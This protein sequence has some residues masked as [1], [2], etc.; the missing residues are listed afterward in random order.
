MLFQDANSLAA[1]YPRFDDFRAVRDRLDPERVFTND[2][3]R[4][5]LGS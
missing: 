1:V 5:V 3:L 2:Y 4:K